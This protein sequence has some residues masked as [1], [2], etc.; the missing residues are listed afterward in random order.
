MKA[1]FNTIQEA[2]S[3]ASSYLEANGQEGLA[4]K[5]FLQDVLQFTSS[6]VMM[7]QFDPFPEDKITKYEKGIEQIAT[8]TPYQYVSGVAEF[9]GR[10]FKVTP[11]VLI[12][13][14]ETE[15][16]IEQLIQR[17]K[18]LFGKRP[19]RIV[20]IGT[21][22]GCIA[23][24]LKLEIPEAEVHAVDISSQA[25]E[26]ARHNAVFLQ[27]DV[28]FL[29]G[30][31]T[32]PIEGEKWDIFVSNPP[33]IAEVEK[34]VM[35]GNVLDHEPHLALF[36]EDEGLYFYK[37]MCARLPE[38]LSAQAIVGFEIGYLQGPA[39]KLLLEQALPTA[40][41]EVVED[42]NGRDRMVFATL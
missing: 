18:T 4:A 24:T 13:R 7:K 11:D 6:D 22:T 39:V 28:Q 19:V 40:K 29:Q 30:D 38:L 2:L 35:H 32:E 31:M 42:L 3:W 20:D 41:V 26:V 37:K 12:P 27:A 36:A 17:K 21:G 34:Q 15:E 5:F 8:G 10:H 1:R 9:Y 25:L 14:P 33:Y 23:T 16:L